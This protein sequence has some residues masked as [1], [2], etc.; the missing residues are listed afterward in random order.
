MF[1][2]GLP[3]A[4]REALAST[5]GTGGGGWLREHRGCCRSVQGATSSNMSN[6]L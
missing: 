5:L 6:L 1:L 4:V 3:W 2:L